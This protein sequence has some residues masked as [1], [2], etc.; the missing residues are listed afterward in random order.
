M[1]I[2]YTAHSRWPD[3]NSNGD[4]RA[5]WDE[6]KKTISDWCVENGIVRFLMLDDGGPLYGKYNEWLLEGDM[7]QVAWLF[8][9]ANDAALFELRWS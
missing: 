8:E 1:R 6:Y 2:V 3:I 4:V 5:Q 9:N 7:D